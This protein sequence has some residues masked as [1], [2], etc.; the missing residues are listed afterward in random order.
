MKNNFLFLDKKFKSVIYFK[1]FFIIA[2]FLFINI[3]NSYAFDIKDYQIISTRISPRASFKE[4]YERVSFV[5]RQV[6]E[7]LKQH[8]KLFKNS[9]YIQSKK[10]LQSAK[11]NLSE[12][13]IA[14]SL[15]EVEKSKYLVDL[16]L[17]SIKTAQLNMMPSRVAEARGIYIDADSIPKTK[18]D[19]TKL[20]KQIKDAHF[21]I[22][23]PEVFRRGY[24]VFDSSI[25]KTD[26]NFRNMSFDVFLYLI[27]EAHLQGLEVHP[28]IWTFR[29]KSPDFGDPILSKY[30]DWASVREF[31]GPNDREPLFLS[32]SSIQARQLI[33]KMIKE[34][35]QR[36]DIDGLLLDYIRY[37]ETNNED[38]LSK[39]Y[40]RLY[41][42]D[43]YGMEPPFRIE[44]KDP[45]FV[46]WQIWR[47]NQVT[48]MVKTVSTEVKRI[49]PNINIGAAIFRTE[50]EGRL[51]KMQDWRLWASNNYIDYVCPMLYTNA[52]YDLDWWIDSETDRDTRNDYL[53]VSLG[54]HKF[55]TPDDLFEQYGILT[56]RHVPGVN[57]F[58]LVHYNKKN[59]PDLSKGIFRNKAV[60][61]DRQPII[62]IKETLK[63][64]S[65]WILR[66]KNNEKS[67]P[68]NQLN[69]MSYE[70][71]KVNNTIPNNNNYKDYLGLNT[72]IDNLKI[73][74]ENYSKKGI[75]TFFIRDI[76]DQLIYAQRLLKV[77]TRQ[78]L[79]ENKVFR[80]SLPPLPI[81]P[82][83]KALPVVDVSPT[84]IQPLI[85]GYIESDLWDNMLPLR[86]FYWHLGSFRSEVETVVKITYG[87]ED[88]Y[89]VFENYEP[90]MSKTKRLST[91]KDS[92]NIFEDDSVEIYL[93][94]PG[95][96]QYYN[97]AVNMNNA[98]FDQR[99]NRS[100]WN[101]TWTSG[102]KIF[103]DKWVAEF[104][105]PFK[106]IEFLPVYGD[107]IRA[108]FVRNRPQEV[109]PV[110]Q[111][112]PTYNGS[113]TPSRF[114]TI[115][116]R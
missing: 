80:S 14:F 109:D 89:V 64:I 33:A 22:I 106:D 46:E 17:E 41:Y 107:S 56:K 6:E 48:E 29:V 85:D 67:L 27:K 104:K 37:D 100:D 42:L 11:N 76:Q 21:N 86:T 4:N 81:L 31:Y 39:K 18:A 38:V 47:E 116:L 65:S 103:E 60:I 50:G 36:Y 5:I 61:P 54:A 79:T 75:N 77:Y 110:S 113:H 26:P 49:K 15:G 97:F 88:L 51:L 63:D 108:N 2:L 62:A 84:N 82:E 94:V 19:I 69:N 70:V 57:I 92:R 83:T 66:I 32:A 45:I 91:T 111:W 105:I 1:Y 35:A 20:I 13:D 44:K 73:S 16:A 71:N 68:S 53:Y 24:T 98:Q 96:N 40:F 25:T 28:W 12:A 23:Y 74:L 30:P 8:S 34:M 7:K 55:E 99:I 59:F 101:G 87:K 115:Y 95:V 102:V 10:D 90:N 52:T 78:K 43:K 72:R 3:S 58:A 9:N 112:S 114:G 93:K